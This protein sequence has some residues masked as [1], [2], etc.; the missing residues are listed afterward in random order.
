MAQNK[1]TLPSQA[2]YN[3]EVADVK[4]KHTTY[5]GQRD[6]IMNMFSKL[7]ET[8]IHSHREYQLC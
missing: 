1:V 4:K 7:L 6:G 5:R 3:I 8:D 2:F